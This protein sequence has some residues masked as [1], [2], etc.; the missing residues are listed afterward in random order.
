MKKRKT[1]TSGEVMRIHQRWKPEIGPRCQRAVIVC[2]ASAR[3]PITIAN[4]I[5]KPIATRSSFSRERIRN[6]PATMI[7]S[8]IASQ[9][10][11]GPHQKSSGAA[12]VRPRMRKQRTRP[13]F[14]GLKMCSPRHL[15]T[16]FESSETAA[17]PTKIHQPFRLHQSPCTV[18]GTRRTNATPLPVSVALAGQRRTCCWRIAIATSS[19]AQ[20]PIASRICA[21]ESSKWNPIWPMTWSEMIT[22]AR[23]SRGSL[24]FGSSTGY[25]LPRIVN[26]GP[27]GAGAACALIRPPHASPLGK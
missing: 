22:A 8:A 21:I 4:V 1:S 15:I 13:M 3:I 23:W 20:V 11:I 26:V 7:A 6:P 12:R 5:Q 17:V 25:G 14:D 16:Y 9:A 18:P 27:E 19:T 10:D 2:P 24:S